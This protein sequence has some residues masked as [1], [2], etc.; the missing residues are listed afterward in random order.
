MF[1]RDS[2]HLW[3]VNGAAKTDLAFL[4]RF[5]VGQPPVV[6]REIG[7]GQQHPSSKMT[8]TGTRISEPPLKKTPPPT[9]FTQSKGYRRGR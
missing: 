4:M 9:G 1:G 7:S 3:H 8:E 2:P 6:S 5:C